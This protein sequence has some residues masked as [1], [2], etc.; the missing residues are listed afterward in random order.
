[1]HVAL[2]CL[3]PFMLNDDYAWFVGYTSCFPLGLEEMKES[4]PLVH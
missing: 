3:H 1:M 4:V 2:V